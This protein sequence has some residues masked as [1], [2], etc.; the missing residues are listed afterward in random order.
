M[1]AAAKSTKKGKKVFRGKKLNEVK[2]LTARTGGRFM[3]EVG[4]S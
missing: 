1:E 3:L 2:P 4:T